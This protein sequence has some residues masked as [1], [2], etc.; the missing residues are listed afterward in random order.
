MST[1]LVD[2]TAAS[3]GITW[4]YQKPLIPSGKLP[5][6][7]GGASMVYADGKLVTF[8]GHW[9][10][11]DDKFAYSDE[12]WLL[13]TEKLVWHKM[14]CSG[15]VPPPRYGHSSA[16]IGSR[17]FIFG[18]KGP[19]GDTYKDVYFLDLVDWIWVAVN[20]VSA[21]PSARFYHACEV[22]G[23]KLVVHGGWNGSELFDDL[24]IFN[25]DTFGWSMPKT[26]GF[27]PSARYGHSLTLCP[28][29]RLV[30]FGGTS[31][32]DPKNGIP[33]YNDD[34]RQ[35]DTDT[36]TWAR[37]RCGGHTP[38]GR[39]GHTAT[40]IDDGCIAIFG[41]WGRGGCQCRES[42]ND[43]RAFSTCICFDVLRAGSL[44]NCSLVS[45]LVVQ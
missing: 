21:G 38:T 16:L 31:F 22:V 13:D 40:L 5:S 44:F 15:Q 18:G 32:D 8:G 26:D 23:R 19:N 2:D 28:D 27:S 34:V 12:T 42:V 11:G 36:M 24:W 20:T 35:L 37:P 14:P 7:R 41:G 33:K 30:M 25:V 29:G 6:G 10:A 4:T 1:S 43:A 45:Y 17:M 9:F 39:F 3:G